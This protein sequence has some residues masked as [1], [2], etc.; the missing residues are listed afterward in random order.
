MPSARSIA[1][2]LVCAS[3]G[4]VPS[5]AEGKVGHV[6]RGG[7][8]IAFAKQPTSVSV[9]GQVI[10]W[11]RRTACPLG[12]RRCYR[13]LIRRRGRTVAVPGVLASADIDLGRGPAGA[14]VA[15]YVRCAAAGACSGYSFDL[16]R[17]L[18]TKLPLAL[19]A[20]CSP[21]GVR[22]AEARV[23]YIQ[24]GKDCSAPG[25]YVA[26]SLTGTVSWNA[27]QTG[28]DREAASA[29]E[30]AGKT[31]FWS[32]ALAGDAD[33]RTQPDGLYRGDLETH[34]HVAIAKGTA[35]A[36][37]GF[38][39]LSLSGQKLFYLLS[40][41]GSE[42]GASVSLQY[43]TI[44][45]PGRWCRIKRLGTDFDPH[46]PGTFLLAVA[47]QGRSVYVVLTREDTTNRK[48]PNRLIRYRLGRLKRSCAR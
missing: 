24:T 36:D 10:A 41:S 20:G 15:T 8:L 38:H 48:H 37:F 9:A 34:A 11:T 30:L 5:V 18:E 13:G 22:I 31:V 45:G 43:R 23:A 29:V 25:L 46:A 3:V 1:T 44:A 12:Q 47:A 35:A 32:T 39:S 21:R 6:P 40:F 19:P 33:S 27:W 16:T 28:T 42:Q 2:L 14:T 17:R 4:L 26:D 7:K